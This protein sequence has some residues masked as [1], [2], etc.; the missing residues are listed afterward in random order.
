V[1]HRITLPVIALLA[2][3]AGVI[4][5]DTPIPPVP[6]VDNPILRYAW[7]APTVVREYSELGHGADNCLQCRREGLWKLIWP[8]H[9]SSDYSYNQIRLS[10]GSCRRLKTSKRF[11]PLLSPAHWR[12]RCGATRE[13]RRCFA[14]IVFYWIAYGP[15]SNFVI[16]A[17]SI[18]G[19]RFLYAPLIAFSGLLALTFEALAR[20]IGTT[21]EFDRQSFRRPWPRLLPHVAFA[22]ILV[23]FGMRTYA[24]NFDWRSNLTIAESEL[25]ESPQSFRGYDSLAEAYY[26]SIRSARSIASLSLA[27]PLSPFSI[28][29]PTSKTEAGAT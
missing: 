9:L 4:F 7:A 10:H 12:S 6:F 15:T 5:R 20:R 25:K 8:T 1:V 21:L 17:R 24:R 2:F 3:R 14:A 23:L 29:C 22:V 11:W 26:D 27:R 13:T 18:M 19:D 28:L 16:D